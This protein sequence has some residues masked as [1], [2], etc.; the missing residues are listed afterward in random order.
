MAAFFSSSLRIMFTGIIHVEARIS[1]SF[2]FIDNIPLYDCTTFCL[3]IC[4]LMG[5]WVASFFIMNHVAMNTS[6]QIFAWTCVFISVERIP[7]SR[8][9]WVVW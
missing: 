6:A 7:G 9:V 4:Q 5:I 1:T 8:V 3:S 2:L